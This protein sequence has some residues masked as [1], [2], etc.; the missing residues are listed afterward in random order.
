ML[1]NLGC[2]VILK[3]KKIK[4]R[5]LIKSIINKIDRASNIIIDTCQKENNLI[6]KLNDSHNRTIKIKGKIT[7]VKRS[8]NLLV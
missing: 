2:K 4:E 1:M 6:E 5:V 7:S 3:L 8:D